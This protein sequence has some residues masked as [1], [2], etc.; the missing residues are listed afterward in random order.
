[1]T[2]AV[3]GGVCGAGQATADSAGATLR[4]TCTLSSFPGQAMT[5]QLAWDAPAT[6][7]VGQAAPTVTVTATATV[8]PT[9]TWALGLVGA[10]TVAG[11]VDAPGVVAAPEGNIGAAVRMIV[12]RTAVPAS[13]PMAVH[14]AGT[15]PGLVFHQPGH[16]TVTVGNDLALHFSPR[17]AGGNPTVTGE[18]DLSC[19]LDP[20]QNA[21]VFSFTITPAPVAAPPVGP[22]TSPAR[23]PTGTGTRETA[24]LS[25]SGS[26][27]S[28]TDST[29]PSTS[30][31]GSAQSTA[32]AAATPT[33][34]RAKIGDLAATSAAFLAAG[35][36][37]AACVWWLMRRRRRHVSGR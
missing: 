4:Y 11:S 30:V 33:A 35:A 23:S 34:E 10:A 32:T 29:A 25:S 28:A 27:L 16:A 18:V 8:G 24:T 22:A 9:V 36:G 2:V 6:V 19:T 37:V 15:T 21:V 13:G 26:S 14:A 12:P 3:S 1:M 7:L 20:G 5:A 17:D 31:S